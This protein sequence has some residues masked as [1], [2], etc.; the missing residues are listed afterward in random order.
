MLYKEILNTSK[1]AGICTKCILSISTQIQTSTPS[2]TQYSYCLVWSTGGIG[3]MLRS[4]PMWSESPALAGFFETTEF[5]VSGLPRVAPLK[6]VLN[7]AVWLTRRGCIFPFLST[8]CNIPNSWPGR[9]TGVSFAVRLH[10]PQPMPSC[11][12]RWSCNVEVAFH[13]YC[14]CSS[15][16]LYPFLSSI[17]GRLEG[18]LRDW[19]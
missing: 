4:C 2:F 15:V 18:D 7:V 19:K 12:R 11:A 10:S 6:A 16:S 14:L 5:K 17:W 9:V 8:R 3:W 1:R 13:S